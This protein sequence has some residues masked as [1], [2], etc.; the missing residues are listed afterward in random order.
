M[1]YTPTRD[2]RKIKKSSKQ[3]T[4]L[5]ALLWGAV[6]ALNEGGRLVVKVV[7]D[8]SLQTRK[9][10]SIF[11]L[12]FSSVTIQ[13]PKPINIQ[14]PAFYLICSGKL[15]VAPW[16]RDYIKNLSY[17]LHALQALWPYD[18]TRVIDL[19]ETEAMKR[20]RLM[21]EGVDYQGRIS[22]ELQRLDSTAQHYAFPI[23]NLDQSPDAI[24]A[25]G[26][27]LREF[28]SVQLKPGQ[29]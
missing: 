26:S 20:V 5:G 25:I 15:P 14:S 6:L 19:A 2:V 23:A 17:D 29:L 16:L 4:C 28:L 8:E 9:V 13:I 3:V 27:E 7:K 24:R 11:G 10:L 18:K 22:R 1:I 12:L 21:V